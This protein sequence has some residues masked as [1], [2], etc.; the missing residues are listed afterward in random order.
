V[1]SVLLIAAS[2]LL[3]RGLE[4]LFDSLGRRE[5][6][7]RVTPAVVFEVLALFDEPRIRARQAFSTS[8]A[9]RAHGLVELTC[10]PDHPDFLDSPI[11]LTATGLRAVLGRMADAA[12]HTPFDPS[13]ATLQTRNSA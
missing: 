9:L 12:T 2:P 10:E 5:L 8:A 6:G 3:Q 4:P 13:R 7:G 1:R 11:T